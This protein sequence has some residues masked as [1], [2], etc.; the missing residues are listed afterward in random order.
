MEAENKGI[1]RLALVC[2]QSWR[3][4][5]KDERRCEPPPCRAFPDQ[6]GRSR[7]RGGGRKLGLMETSNPYTS[8]S[9][10]NL[11]LVDCKGG[12]GATTPEST[13]RNS[14]TVG[15]CHLPSMAEMKCDWQVTW[16]RGAKVM[17]WRSLW[18]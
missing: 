14:P 1:K 6:H 17:L 10:L 8:T 7:A 9:A 16:L 13:L 2:N 5:G 11:S 18:F 15:L 4:N 3:E 12:K